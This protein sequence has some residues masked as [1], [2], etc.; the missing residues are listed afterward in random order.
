V[1]AHAAHQRERV[2]ADIQELE[3]L[4]TTEREPDR[5][6]RAPRAVSSELLRQRW[7]V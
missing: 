2:V 7:R 1:R 3:R 5:R 6:S 4:H